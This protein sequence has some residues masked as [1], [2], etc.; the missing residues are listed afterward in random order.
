MSKVVQ[1]LTTKEVKIEPPLLYESERKKG[2]P[3]E[4]AAVRVANNQQSMSRSGFLSS[5]RTL[6]MPE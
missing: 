6:S 1:S 2:R 5:A 4:A 3:K